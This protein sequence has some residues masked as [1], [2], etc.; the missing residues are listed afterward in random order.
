MTQR[1]LNMIQ[2]AEDGLILAREH[3]TGNGALER[4]MD[5]LRSDFFSEDHKSLTI[6]RAVYLAAALTVWKDAGGPDLTD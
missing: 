5:V 6:G 1:Q 4:A 2:S 3:F